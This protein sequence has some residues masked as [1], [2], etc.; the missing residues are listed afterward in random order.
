MRTFVVEAPQRTALVVVAEK[1]V[2][3]GTHQKEFVERLMDVLGCLTPPDRQRKL[4]LLI[5]DFKTHDDLFGKEAENNNSLVQVRVSL[6]GSLL[7]QRLFTFN[8]PDAVFNSFMAL[9]PA[10]LSAFACDPSGCHVFD[11]MF[12]SAFL[13]DARMNK[14]VSRMKSSLVAM[15][16]DKCGSRVVDALWKRASLKNKTDVAEALTKQLGRVAGDRFGKFIARNLQLDNFSLRRD[17][18]VKNVEAKMNSEN[19]NLVNGR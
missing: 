19:G 17:Q 13:D 4:A 3:F 15:A 14:L 2:E 6:Q 10:Q 9:P 8:S 18:W 11:A 7:L 12:Q 5:A 16:T 1:C